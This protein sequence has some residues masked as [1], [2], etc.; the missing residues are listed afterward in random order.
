MITTN[1]KA[2][3]TIPVSQM[4]WK[5]STGKYEFRAGGGLDMVE[6]DDRP[7]TCRPTAVGNFYGYCK[8][9]ECLTERET[10]N[11]V[12]EKIIYYADNSTEATVRDEF[13]NAY[14]VMLVAPHGDA[15]F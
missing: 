2:G 6:Q 12:V 13:N 9:G 4:F 3:D 10:R 8:C 7:E 14:Q 5:M 15:C 11:M 1:V